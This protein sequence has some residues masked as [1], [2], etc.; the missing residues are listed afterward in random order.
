MTNLYPATRLFFSMIVC[1]ASFSSW[2]EPASRKTEAAN[3]EKVDALVKAKMDEE[4]VPGLVL[5]VIKDGKILKLQ[6]Y[7][8]ADRMQCLSSWLL[9]PI[10]RGNIFS[11]R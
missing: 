2:C 3:G 4:H 1:F 8:F 6:A 5:A 9:Q 10:S 7:G 11:G